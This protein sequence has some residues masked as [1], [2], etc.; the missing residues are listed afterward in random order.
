M[1]QRTPPARTSGRGSRKVAPV[2]KPFPVGFAVG[3]AALAAV[4]I[5]VIVFAVQNQGIATR[6][7]GLRSASGLD[8]NHVAGVVSYPQRD[9]TPPDSG[10]H[11]PLPQSCMVYSA[12]IPD[13][14]AVHSLEHGA[15]WVTY[16]PAKLSQA[17]VA[18]LA[19]KVEGNPYRL[20]SPYPGLKS[21]VS[22]Q[23]WGKQLFLS[24]PS[25]SRLDKF[26]N[27]FTN[28]PQT[29]EPGSACT[30]NTSTGTTPKTT[31]P[32]G[33]ILPPTT[34]QLPGSAGTPAPKG[35]AAPGTVKK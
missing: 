7:D 15:V 33:S 13:E 17:Q 18:L 16:D 19:A 8:R 34:G 12:Q 35:S 28:G 23:A 24:N 2:K 29:P 14:H 3:C 25:D 27:R 5:A 32:D 6:I 1:A 26:L 21:A 10:N 11:N 20:M 22:L 4:L 9:N 30:G 31:G